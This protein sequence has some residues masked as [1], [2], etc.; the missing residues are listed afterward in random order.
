MLF[1]SFNIWP[2]LDHNQWPSSALPRPRDQA[3]HWSWWITLPPF[4]PSGP[5]RSSI[6][7][8]THSH[9]SLAYPHFPILTVPVFLFSSPSH[10][11]FF[12]CSTP[13]YPPTP[14]S[15]SSPQGLAGLA[16]TQSPSISS[17]SDII[18][19]EK[20]WEHSFPMIL[21]WYHRHSGQGWLAG[22]PS[23]WFDDWVTG[24]PWKKRTEAHILAGLASGLSPIPA[25][26][27]LSVIK[28]QHH[29]K[30]SA[31]WNY[32]R[33]VLNVT[34]LYSV[35]VNCIIHKNDQCLLLISVL[36]L[37]PLFFKTYTADYVTL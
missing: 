28:A 11:L 30:M 31:V 15:S 10:L 9:A 16:S 1:M 36:L 29:Y 25:S 33:N 14:S 27:H 20:S 34:H 21:K 35:V 5:W 37:Q 3:S 7:L 19:T 13:S 8:S 26:K 4:Q 22:W 32:S 12:P 24:W 17:I 18:R 23:G 2:S 6:S